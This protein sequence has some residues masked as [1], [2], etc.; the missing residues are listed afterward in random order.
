M[1]GGEPPVP[2]L[3]CFR[4]HTR[5]IPLHVHTQLAPVCPLPG[6]PSLSPAFVTR[7]VRTAPRGPTGVT[8]SACGHP[9][10]QGRAFGSR[11]G[12]RGESGASLL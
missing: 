5:S 1:C 11:P 12:T 7:P 4:I 10:S 9:D 3:V 8:L 2:T 6:H